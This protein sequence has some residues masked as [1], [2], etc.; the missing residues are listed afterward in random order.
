MAVEGFCELDRE[1]E[2]EPPLIRTALASSLRRLA[3]R[4]PKGDRPWRSDL[5][6]GVG[7]LL[8]CG[9]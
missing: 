6:G 9:I 4:S 2:G 5:A 8:S 3:S 7:M 1:T